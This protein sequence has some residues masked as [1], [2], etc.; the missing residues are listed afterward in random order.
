MSI[1]DEVKYYGERVP[2][3]STPTMKQLKN[4]KNEKSPIKKNKE[5]EIFFPKVN[6]IISF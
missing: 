2:F 1:F 3:Y 6:S 4:K 5:N